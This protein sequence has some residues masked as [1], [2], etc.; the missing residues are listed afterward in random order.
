MLTIIDGVISRLGEA[1]EAWVR[2]DKSRTLGH[3]IM[4]ARRLSD[5][6]H[7]AVDEALS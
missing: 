1:R 3:L 6:Q 5:A 2:G 4:A 7:L